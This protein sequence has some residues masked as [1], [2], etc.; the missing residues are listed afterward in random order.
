M[1]TGQTASYEDAIRARPR[2]LTRV[3]G[4]RPVDPVERAAWLWDEQRRLQAADPPRHPGDRARGVPDRPRR[5]EGGDLPDAARVGR[6]LRPGA[7]ARR[8]RGSSA[9]RCARSAST[10]ASRPCSTSSA[11]RAGAGSRSASREDPYLVGTIGT[12][13]VRGLQDAGRARDA[14]ALRRLLG[15]AGRA[16]PR[17]GA[18]RAA[19]DRRRA[20]AA[21]RD[22]G[23]RRRGALGHELVHRDRRRAGR[24]RRRAAH[25]AAARDAGA[26][27]ASSSPTTSP[28]RSCTSM[29]AVAADRGEAAALALAAGHRRRAAHR[30][31]LSSQ[32]LADRVRARRRSTR[33]SSTAPCCACSR[34]RRSSA[35][36]TT[37]FEA[38]R[39]PVIDLDSPAH[40]EVARRLAEESIVLLSNDG[41][42]PLGT[43]S[44]VPTQVAVIGP[45]ADRA[46]ALMGCYSFVNHVLAHHPE[47]PLGFEIPTVFEA[48]RA[49]FELPE[50]RDRIR[51]RRRLRGRGRR[52][53][54]ASPRP[55]RPRRRP[56]VAVVVVGDH[57]GLFGR[58]TVG[59]GNDVG[60]LELPGR[61]A[62]AR[63]GGRRA[64]ARPSSWSCSPVGRTRSAGRS[65]MVP[66]GPAPCCRPSSPARRAAARSPTSSP[67]GSNPSGR[68]PVT[69]PR[70]AGRSP[71]PTCTRSS[72]ARPT[73]PRPTP[74]R[75]SLRLR[76]VLHLLRVFRTGRRRRRARGRELY[77]S[78]HGDEHGRGS[79]CRRRAAVRT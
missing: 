57:A 41:V 17:A 50:C 38:S 32:P 29:H 55:W 76:T 70:S 66:H 14:Q 7:R 63:R 30:R 21:V 26:S 4:T 40:R 78:G 5:V 49:A 2:A 3:Y 12:A 42:L 27:T 79:R 51:L 75:C 60:D 65:R 52:P 18:R 28:W 47:V 19:R 9:A 24:G 39:R 54:P 73:S 77:G 45:N 6:G 53:R 15:L 16:Q 11:I 34:R 20:A 23:A 43:R 1:A 58:G 46:E 33:R 13:Y 71:T 56:S 67:G 35:C 59:E 48:L 74:P 68:L 22:G 44:A 8:W 31:R 72:A 64:P 61:A 36:S 37:T 62:R 25:R 10:R 69:L